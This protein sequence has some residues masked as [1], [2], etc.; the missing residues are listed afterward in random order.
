VAKTNSDFLRFVN[1]AAFILTLTVNSLAGTTLLNGRTTA[2]VSD[3]YANPFTPA[4]YVFAIW[5]I[6]YMLLAVFVVYQALPKQKE[7]VF[8]KQVSALFVLSSVLNVIWLFLWQ[9]NYITESVFVMF[10]LLASLTL[11]YVRLGIGKSAASLTEKLC[12]HLPFSVY[13]GWITVASIANVAA[14]LVSVGWDGFGLSAQTWTIVAMVTALIVTLAVIVARKDAA[15]SL[16]AV[17]ALVGIA[18]KQSIYPNI[19]LTAEAAVAV[20]LVALLVSI[21]AWRLKRKGRMKS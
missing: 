21:A 20:I 4:G 10:A 9:Y 19:V 16:V 17:W 8:Q 2:Q 7:K 3:L 11:I 15:Y 14:A 13:I 12:V 6:I 18:V 1:I 5:G